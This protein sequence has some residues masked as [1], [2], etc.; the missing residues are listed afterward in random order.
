MD[1]RERFATTGSISHKKYSSVCKLTHKIAMVVLY[2]PFFYFFSNNSFSSFGS[3]KC[4]DDRVISDIESFARHDLLDLLKDNRQ[5]DNEVMSYFYGDFATE[6]NNFR[7]SQ[8]ERCLILSLVQHVN[9]SSGIDDLNNEFEKLSLQAENMSRIS[10]L[11]WY[12]KHFQNS[13]INFNAIDE[14]EIEIE[15]QIDKIET[16]THYVL[17]KLLETAN[18]NHSRP[19]AGRR[20]NREV[21]QWALS[22]RIIAGPTGYSMVQKNLELALPSLSRIN[23]H[24]HNKGPMIIEGVPRFEELKIYLNER[25]MPP[26]VSLSE[27]ATRIEN[28]VQYDSKKNI[29]VG[30][31][32]PLN[33]NG[34]PIPLVFKARHTDEI[35]QH[36]CNNTP[37]STNIITIMAQPIGNAPSFCLLV[38]GTKNEFVGEDVARRW[39]YLTDQLKLI[40]INVLTISSDSDPKYNRAMRKNSHLGCQSKTFDG[41]WFKCGD[42]DATIPYYVQDTPH[43]VCKLRNILIKTR[44]YPQ[45]LKFGVFYIQLAHLQFVLDHFPKDYH[46]LTQTILKPE[47]RQNFS[48]VLRI[49][50]HKVLQLLR[51]NVENS[52][53]TVKYLEIIRD[54][55]D[56]YMDES[57]SPLDRISKLWYSI[58]LVRIW[59][60]Y[61]LKTPHL[62]LRDNFIT[63]NTF[64]CMEHNAH[65]M[66]QIILFLKATNQPKYFKPWL[67][68]S[69]P[70][71]GF[72]RLIRSFTP[73]F[74][75]VTNCTVKDFLHR[76]HKIE[77]QKEISSDSSNNFIF[78]EKIKTKNDT[79]TNDF[80]LPN[81]NE[82]L[83]TILKAKKEAIDNAIGF[84][85]INENERNVDLVCHIMP[86][87]PKASKLIEDEV[88]NE[89]IELVL[90]QLKHTKLKNFADEFGEEPIDTT[91]QYTEI[92]GSVERIIIK[93]MSL[94]WLLRKDGQKLSS[95][96]LLRVQIKSAKMKCNKRKRAPVKHFSNRYTWLQFNKR[97]VNK[98]YK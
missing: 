97:K 49:C 55:H 71:E 10:G 21:K 86:W 63:W 88:M 89:S 59:R 20:F 9:E 58:F 95:D 85:L 96:R 70:C 38:F 19:K 4:I 43:T 90:E 8:D 56:A 65:A 41:E 78:S 13:D 28:R 51:D 81:K 33:Q 92:F 83:Q 27:D 24:M 91:S 14:N 47:D 31:V 22:L 36:F 15:P 53:A 42:G 62:T 48:S 69:Q 76:V 11:T 29:L 7:F 84:G 57:I 67:Y 66:V 46:Q 40:G 68:S 39:N 77:L 30:F 5:V 82:I 87:T 98:R 73:C 3:F 79:Q 32:P 37:T 25:N 72:Y 35:V 54:F 17:Q 26:I 45:M 34:M 94:C 16:Q 2:I 61:V 23:Y 1:N 80:L 50:D 93:K 64:S 60:Q 75:Q 6:P 44:K 52:A 74:S 18:Q 12:F